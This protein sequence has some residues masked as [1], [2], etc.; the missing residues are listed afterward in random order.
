[1]SR[2]PY[3][4]VGRSLYK[5]RILCFQVAISVCRSG[6]SYSSPRHY[7]CRI[8]SSSSCEP[9]SLSWERN[10]RGGPSQATC[11]KDWLLQPF[12]FISLV[13]FILAFSF[14]FRSSIQLKL[15][16][17]LYWQT[18]N[19]SIK[20]RPICCNH[21]N[22]FIYMS[23]RSSYDVHEQSPNSCGLWRVYI[24]FILFGLQEIVRV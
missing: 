5:L 23:L 13:M 1:M 20:R 2:I 7:H 24:F 12:Q 15:R 21:R 14:F 9:T 8:R 6:F 19:K 11:W 4:R 17:F 3:G 22:P 18:Q 10:P 16:Y